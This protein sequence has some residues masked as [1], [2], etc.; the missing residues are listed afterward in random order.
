LS[1]GESLPQ[2][3]RR[4]NHMEPLLIGSDRELRT[5]VLKS[6]CVFTWI[7]VLADLMTDQQSHQPTF[8]NA[9]VALA[10]HPIT[11]TSFQPL[12]SKSYKG[13][14]DVV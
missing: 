5:L 7:E 14:W 2:N 9:A 10:Y 1:G 13:D 11:H 3:P 6:T 8:P 12:C 4:V